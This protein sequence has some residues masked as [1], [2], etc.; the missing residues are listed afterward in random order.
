MQQL[1]VFLKEAS[2]QELLPTIRRFVSVLTFLCNMSHCAAYW[3]GLPNVHSVH[4]HV[5]PHRGG[6]I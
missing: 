2:H 6:K 1:K 4:V 5:R 3:A